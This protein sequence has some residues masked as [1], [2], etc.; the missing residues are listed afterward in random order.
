MRFAGDVYAFENQLYFV[1]KDES[2]GFPADAYDADTA[3]FYFLPSAQAVA[4]LIDENDDARMGLAFWEDAA[5]G[6]I[7]YTLQNAFPA[8]LDYGDT[9][10]LDNDF[11][12]VVP[13][14]LT[15]GYTGDISLTGNGNLLTVLNLGSVITSHTQITID[16][17][18]SAAS[19]TLPDTNTSTFSFS[20]QRWLSY[21]TTDANGDP[22]RVGVYIGIADDDSVGD[23]IFRA[24]TVLEDIHEIIVYGIA[25]IDSVFFNPSFVPSTLVS[26]EFYGGLANDGLTGISDNTSTRLYGEQGGDNIQGHS[27]DILYGGSGD[28]N[29]SSIYVDGVTNL[30]IF[31]GDDNDRIDGGSGDERLYGGSGR[32]IIFSNDG[33]DVIFGGSGNDQLHA[34][35]GVDIFVFDGNGDG[36]DQVG[37]PSTDYGDD[38]FQNEDKLYFINT[39]MTSRDDLSIS[40]TVINANE[41]VSIAY[42]DAPL[43]DNINLFQVDIEDTHLI[44]RS[45]IVFEN[46][47]GNVTVNVDEGG[48]R[49]SLLASDHGRKL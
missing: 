35:S 40:A 10:I 17:A 28:D 11:S 44:R 14:E 36:S 38:I 5:G 20:S 42:T 25:G 45:D 39:T 49:S 13:L 26:G 37:T 18:T 47:N 48:N 2:A 8:T 27:H 3:D 4:D 7:I 19:L 24:S 41:V 23:E 9:L 21:T 1:P 29:I 32:D 46:T 31:G 16:A 12:G 34:G 43:V 22:W 33:H 30:T 15:D 6:L